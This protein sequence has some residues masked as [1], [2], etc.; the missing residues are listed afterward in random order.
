MDEKQKNAALNYL[1]Y[2]LSKKE[3]E[4]FDSMPAIIPINTMKYTAENLLQ[5]KP[6]YQPLI[7]KNKSELTVTILG[8]G[9]IGT[10]MFLA[11]YWFGQILD[12]K[13][14]I[15]VISKEKQSST[16][17]IDSVEKSFEGRLNWICPEIL[18][19]GKTESELLKYS[20]GNK[21]I[22]YSPPYMDYKYYQADV[23]SDLFTRLFNEKRIS[24]TDYYIVALGYDEDD[25]VVA[26]KI[27][28]I[29]AEKHF[30]DMT[31]PKTVISYLIYNSELCRKLNENSKRHY[32]AEDEMSDIYMN[33]FG[34]LEDVYNIRNVFQDGIIY[35]A[36]RTGQRYAGNDKDSFRIYKDM[37][38]YESNLARKAHMK[39]KVFSAGFYEKSMFTDEQN[40]TENESG[41]LYDPAEEK[42]EYFAKCNV[43]DGKTDEEKKKLRHRLAW[44]EHRRW[45]AY[46]R[47]RGFRSIGFYEVKKFYGLASSEHDLY[48]HKFISLKLHP[49][50]IECSENGI[51]SGLNDIGYVDLE[52][53]VKDYDKTRDIDKLDELSLNIKDLK[54]CVEKSDDFKKWDYPEF[55]EYY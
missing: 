32:N 23:K 49:C 28:K 40:Y 30:N 47:S 35:A 51:L 48:D 20:T 44:L 38:S 4:I 36:D 31:C 52:N 5:Q 37:Y 11:V 39:Y 45:C 15:N 46:M 27:R 7:G 24:D 18:E 14:K 12:C 3:R 50:I 41:S 43:Y 33:A 1:Q 53:E 26:D 22:R 55:E 2:L 19:S 34:C 6:L 54:K 10:E 8:S 21:N 42:F 9:S 25:F 16:Y 17:G 29:V 13:L